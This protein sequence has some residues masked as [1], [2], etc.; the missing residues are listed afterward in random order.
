MDTV[1]KARGNPFKATPLPPT[2]CLVCK[3][4]LNDLYKGSVDVLTIGQ[5][6]DH[7]VWVEGSSRADFE[8]LFAPERRAREEAAAR[9][10]ELAALD[11]V[12]KLLR[13]VDQL[14]RIVA[15]LQAEIATLKSRL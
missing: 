8:A 15:E 5:C 13:R 1:A 11:P 10:A 12:A 3:K 7:G 9:A 6:L 2:R 14:E 4:P